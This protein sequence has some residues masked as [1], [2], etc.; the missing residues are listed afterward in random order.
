[1][2]EGKTGFSYTPGDIDGLVDRLERLIA[3]PPLWSEMGS[4]GQSHAWKLFSKDNFSGEVYRTLQKLRRN[5]R[6]S[7]G[8]PRSI[9]KFI[10]EATNAPVFPAP[11]NIHRS[12]PCPCGSGKRYKHCHGRFI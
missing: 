2:V 1:M 4:F 8:M 11:R 9:E 3:D 10:A 7:T 12:N 5:G 6:K